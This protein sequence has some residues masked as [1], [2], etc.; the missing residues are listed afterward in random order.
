MGASGPEERPTRPAG[1]E[2]EVRRLRQLA[3]VAILAA[4]ALAGYA[5]LTRP[6]PGRVAVAG[7]VEIRDDQ[8]RLRGSF[9]LDRNGLP[10]V[11]LYDHRGHEQ[12][13]LAISSG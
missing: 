5:L 1:L 2:A 12:V 9:G 7:G 3:A 13:A 6:R 11:K 10:S 4:F 8:G